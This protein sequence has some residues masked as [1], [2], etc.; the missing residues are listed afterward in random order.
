MLKLGVIFAL[1]CFN[2][3]S[4]CH[5]AENETRQL[6]LQESILLAVR[7]N[8]NVQITQLSHVLQ[9]FAVEVQEWEFSPH[10]AFEAKHTT[11]SIYSVTTDGQVTSNV[12]GV[13]PSASLLTPIGT[14]ITAASVNNV[15]DHYN[16]G[17]SLQVI[18]PLMKGFGRPIVEAELYNALDSEKISRL[19]LQGELRDTVTAVINAYL[20]VI[21]AKN[22]LSFPLNGPPEAVK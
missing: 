18:Q 1:I 12:S 19:N 5:A 10:Y 15:T 4:V 21:S 22:N 14:R 17:L 13:Q 6:S 2:G 9:K 11:T 20:D 7:K 3:I 8:P 16:P